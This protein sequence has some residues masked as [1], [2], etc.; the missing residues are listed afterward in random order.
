MVKTKLSSPEAKIDASGS[1][2]IRLFCNVFKIKFARCGV[3]NDE[4]KPCELF[5][6]ATNKNIYSSSFSIYENF[7]IRLTKDY[8]PGR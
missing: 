6:N 5:M 4:I 3:M 1:L 7:V 2:V 8:F